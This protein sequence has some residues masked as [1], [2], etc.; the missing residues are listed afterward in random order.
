MSRTANSKAKKTTEISREIR[1][2]R[3]SSMMTLLDHPFI[4]SVQ[5]MVLMDDYYYLFMEYVDG[6]QLLDYVISHGRLKE[7]QA[8]LFSRQIASA[9]GK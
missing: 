8:R 2:I 7:K 4:A 5:E 3:E 9:L 6:G 1:T